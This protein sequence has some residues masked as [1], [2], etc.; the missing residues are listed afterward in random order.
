MM[1][2]SSNMVVL[3]SS[4]V[5]SPASFELRQG[6]TVEE[7]ID[8]GRS[9]CRL[10][11]L[12]MWKFGEWWDYGENAY[13]RAYGDR[14]SYVQEDEWDG[15]SFQSC[16][17]AAWVHRKFKTSRRREVLSFYAHREVAALPEQWQDEVLT[18]AENGGNRPH[19]IKEIRDRV[20]QVKAYLAQ[21]WTPDQLDR[22]ARAEAGECVV[23]NI[24][25]DKDGRRVDDALLAWAEANDRFVRI[26]RKTEWGN[27]FEMPDDGER[28]EVVGKFA[29]FYLPHKDGLL[30]R[31]NEIAGR[32][33]VLG[34][35]CH[36]EE[37]HGHIIAEVAN[38][39][40]TGEGR[41]EDIA[42]LVS[43]YDG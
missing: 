13:K 40:A 16:M 15:P 37:C 4:D 5:L 35:W 41:A 18:W 12:C 31:I 14:I 19:T 8:V 1:A 34:C 24:H 2:K 17:D 36:P 26:D 29:K 3:P 20:K 25:E 9:L 33:K 30:A 21:G 27:P 42:D 6:L 10:H 11:N 39:V 7:W 43:E 38:R 23:A 32:G 22:K 28:A